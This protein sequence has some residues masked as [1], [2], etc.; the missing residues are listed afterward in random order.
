M[1]SDDD[2]AVAVDDKDDEV[3]VDD[4]VLVAFVAGVAIDEVVVLVLAP[5]ADD[6]ECACDKGDGA[7]D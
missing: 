1:D 4:E 6:D 7:G 2:V 3:D 5:S